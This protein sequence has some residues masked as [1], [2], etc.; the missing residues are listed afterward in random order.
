MV[1]RHKS[2]I[3]NNVFLEICR[4]DYQMNV[5][6]AILWSAQAASALLFAHSEGILHGNV[7]TEK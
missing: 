7:K 1:A 4:Q 2:L 6:T 5:K 3:F